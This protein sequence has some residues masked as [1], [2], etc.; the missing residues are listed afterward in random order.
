MISGLAVSYFSLSN[1]APQKFV[2]FRQF[3]VALLNLLESLVRPSPT[4]FSG[5]Q[6]CNSFA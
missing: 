6:R 3:A 2:G 1:L 4:R 5:L